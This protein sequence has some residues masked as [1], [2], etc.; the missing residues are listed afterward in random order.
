[1]YVRCT[2]IIHRV[3]SLNILFPRITVRAVYNTGESVDSNPVVASLNPTKPTTQNPQTDQNPDHSSDEDTGGPKKGHHLPPPLSRGEPSTIQ[4]TSEDQ[5]D[6]R[7]TSQETSN[8][9]QDGQDQPGNEADN[10]HTEDSEHSSDHEALMELVTSN[11]QDIILQP[12]ASQKESPP[13]EELPGSPPFHF[14]KAKHITIDTVSVLSGCT[15]EYS[16]PEP[17][18]ST[19]ADTL[20]GESSLE[21]D[22]ESSSDTDSTSAIDE[23]TEEVC[24]GSSE[25]ATLSEQAST[26]NDASI[27]ANNAKEGVVDTP[28]TEPSSIPT[29]NI[30]FSHRSPQSVQSVPTGLHTTEVYTPVS[31]NFLGMLPAMTP[32]MV[33]DSD[34]LLSLG[35]LG[36][37]NLMTGPHFDTLQNRNNTSHVSVNTLDVCT[38]KT[39]QLLKDNGGVQSDTDIPYTHTSLI[40]PKMHSSVSATVVSSVTLP[41]TPEITSMVDSH[42]IPEQPG[43]SVDRNYREDSKALG[44]D[45]VKNNELVSNDTDHAIVTQ[46]GG[47]S[48]EKEH[49]L[50]VSHEPSH[51]ELSPNIMPGSQQADTLDLPTANM[52]PPEQESSSSSSVELASQLLLELEKDLSQST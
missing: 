23:S 52:S 41:D 31:K 22:K 43:V 34:Q 36:E 20:L 9:V 48:M 33:Q 14:Q 24:V 6:S 42:T 46:V 35:T 45:N 32:G 50:P 13:R 51:L 25:Q 3:C 29:E 26:V 4:G 18:A 44:R 19:S 37:H 16:P 40:T 1:M 27:I 47:S 5:H 30:S 49:I 2:Y 28:P 38:S 8:Q 11:Q 10:M 7:N 17:V 21:A 15:I 12:L 39:I